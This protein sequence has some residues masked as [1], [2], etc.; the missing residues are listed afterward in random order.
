MS[1][2]LDKIESQLIREGP[3]YKPME[4]LISEVRRL[5]DEAEGRSWDL[6][7]PSV[8]AAAHRTVY[9]YGECPMCALIAARLPVVV[10]PEQPR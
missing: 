8:C 7:V 6:P 3:L 5:R 1:I 4:A 10:L 2:D 9:F